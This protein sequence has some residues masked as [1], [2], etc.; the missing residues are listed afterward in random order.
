MT[1]AVGHVVIFVQENHQSP[2]L[3][4]PPRNALDFR[5]DGYGGT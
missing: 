2:T 1:D 5:T 4:N 3:R